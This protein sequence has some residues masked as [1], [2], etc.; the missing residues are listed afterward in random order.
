MY[1][2]CTC[3]DPLPNQ[4]V[5]GGASD[6]GE[7][8]PDVISLDVADGSEDG[9][10]PD[11][12]IIDKDVPPLEKPDLAEATVDGVSW[13]FDSYAAANFVM[14]TVPEEEGG[15]TPVNEGVLQIVMASGQ[16]QLE[17]QETIFQ[18]HLQNLLLIRFLI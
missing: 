3:G 14:A 2:F 11:V 9:G 8:V 13:E 18:N 17:L 5:D 7:L 12:I 6:G 15:D 4:T 16:M 1:G 10:V